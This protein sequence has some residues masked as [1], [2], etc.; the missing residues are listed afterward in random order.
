MGR[1][2]KMKNIDAATAGAASAF[3][4]VVVQEEISTIKKSPSIQTKKTEKIGRMVY[5]IPTSLYEAIDETGEAF[6]S[7][8]KRAMQRLAKEEGI[9]K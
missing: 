3:K 5:G 7:F 6:S 2:N 4:E 1:Y 9:L 8:A